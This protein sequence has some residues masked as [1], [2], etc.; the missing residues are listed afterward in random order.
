[1]EETKEEK[2]ELKS[3]TADGESPPA[4]KVRGRGPG[5]EGTVLLGQTPGEEGEEG[6]GEGGQ[7]SWVQREG[8]PA[9]CWC[10]EGCV[11]R[12][13]GVF[14]SR[15]LSLDWG[16]ISRLPEASKAVDVV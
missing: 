7:Q 2:I 1:M 8:R 10:P 14:L 15:Q 6:A 11:Q 9:L 3:I 5:E 13:E 4:T 12:K 16:A